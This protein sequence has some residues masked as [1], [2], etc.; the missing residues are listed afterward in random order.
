VARPA[1]PF[2]SGRIKLIKPRLRSIVDFDHLR[3]A[4]SVLS[5]AQLFEP[6]PLLTPPADILTHTSTISASL[7]EIIIM[8]LF[9]GILG[10]GSPFDARQ[11]P[12]A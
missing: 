4:T 2:Q 6:T 7:K 1:E 3:T 12:I 8:T 9:I 5:G 10:S 11:C